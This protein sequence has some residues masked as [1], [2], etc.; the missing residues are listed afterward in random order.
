MPHTI[1][2]SSGEQHVLGILV[3]TSAAADCVS[4][5]RPVSSLALG[6]WTFASEEFPG[7]NAAAVSVVPVEIDCVFA[8][9][10][11]FE[12]A[13]WLFIHRQGA[14]FG[15]WRLAD[16]ASGGFTFFVASGAWAGIAQPGE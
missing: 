11:D 7:I 5:L 2:S 10:S 14:W 4:T 1:C 12:R 16:F 6:T 8:Y 13:S 3:E 9:G 15:L